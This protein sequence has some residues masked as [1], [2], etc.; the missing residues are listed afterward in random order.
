MSLHLL[1]GTTK[2][3]I[4][5]INIADENDNINEPFYIKELKIKIINTILI[6]ISNDNLDSIVDKN[7]LVS[8]Y[9]DKIQ[10]FINIYNSSFD[11]VTY[12]YILDTVSYAITY[13]NIIVVSRR[14]NF[15]GN[16]FG[17]TQKDLGIIDIKA[18]YILYD[19][20]IGKPKFKNNETYNT[21]IINDIKM[22][23]NNLNIDFYK[24]RDFIL[25]KY[26]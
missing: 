19:Q 13:H 23:L 8:F 10:E 7:Y 5:L 24:I 14:I 26:K 11:L 25:E 4:N 2:Q 16:Q 12:K 21:L 3:Y 15:N 20:I 22:L 9:K 6:P 18:E 17:K 1:T